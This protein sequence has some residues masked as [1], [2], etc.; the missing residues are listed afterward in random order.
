MVAR[1]VADRDGA[2]ER[3]SRQ[4]VVLAGILFVTLLVAYL[5]RVNVSVL[6]ADPT[7]LSDM[8]IEGD[9]VRKGLLM[10]LF[11]LAYGAANVLLSP[12]GDLLGPRKAMSLSV[13]LWGVALVIGGLA[14]SF[15]TMA[16]S[17]LALGVGE[18]MHW[19]MQSKYVKHWFPPSERG[20]ANSAWLVGLM[21]G[22]ALAM[23]FFTWI[24]G[25]LGWRPSFFLLAALGLGPLALL[26][27]FTTDHPDQHPRVNRA[28]LDHI[29]KGL[30]M[31]AEAMES[32]DN[33][34]SA[35]RSL[36]S[37]M[38][39]WLL[40]VFYSCSASVWWGAMT[41]LPS[42]LKTERGFSWSAMGVWAA[43]PYI[44]G[45]VCIVVVGFVTDRTGRH[46]LFAAGAM[47]GAA[48]GVFLGGV[49]S[50]NTMATVFLSLG[51]ASISVGLPAAWTLLQRIVPARTM[52]A[53]AGAMNGVANG[54]SALSPV[55][56][57]WFMLPPLGFLAGLLFLVSLA[58]LGFACMVV[59]VI[60]RV[61]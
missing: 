35:A 26:W 17:R 22:P 30:S 52:G 43:V 46:A 33:L 39:F 41:W 8:G 37:D 4:R 21:I 42:Y 6:V 12:I 38:R 10:T 28:E 61:K 36:F 14:G 34:V 19:P 7:F 51:I 44:L 57:G 40:T 31:E 15:G 48:T 9:P 53:G 59:L 55:A 2:F 23:P 58:L 25:D 27:F 3:P 60:E 5:D 54:L 11:L 24:I 32:P 20:R 50:D 49:V 18:G 45:A 13:V 16:A 1:P 47:L 56:V 29:Q